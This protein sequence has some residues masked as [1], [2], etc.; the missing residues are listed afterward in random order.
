MTS[1]GRNERGTQP[2]PKQGMARIPRFAVS[3]AANV[4][5]HSFAVRDVNGE[6]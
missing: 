6:K 4:A 3:L 2:T 1:I 5:S